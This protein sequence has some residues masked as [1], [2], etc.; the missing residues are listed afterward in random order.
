MKKSIGLIALVL[1][2]F[3]S[4][5]AQE[6]LFQRT[7]GGS[8]AENSYAIE[9]TL[10]GGYISVG[11]TESF[12]KGKKDMLVVKTD[13]MGQV[14]WSSAYGESGDD[15]AWNV[16]VANDSGYVV[17]GNSTSYKANGDAIAV[18]LDKSGK[19]EWARTVASDSLEDGYNII[20]SLYSNGYYITG[21]VKN[22]SN[23]DQGF[24]AK[25]GTGG[26]IRWYKTFGSPGNEEA[27]G[28]AEDGRG[29]VVITGQTTYD[30][31]TNGGLTGSSGSSDA[32]IAKF[33][34][35]GG[36]KWMK[37]Y[38]S[39]ADD[40][41][42]DIKVDRNTYI[43][44]GWTK[45][46]SVGDNDVFVMTCDTSGN[47]VNAQ[48]LGTTGDD[49]GFDIAI[50]P[51]N[52]GFAVVGYAEPQV[53][54]REVLYCDFNSSGALSTSLLVGGSSRD[55]HWPT[56]VTKSGDG[57]FVVL[58]TSRSFNTTGN[59]D[60]YLAKIRKDGST[61]CN[62]TLDPIN[63]FTLNLNSTSFGGALVGLTTQTP[64]VSRTTIST[65]SDSTLCCKL[66]AA[67][68]KTQLEVCA[69]RN[70]SIGSTG[71]RGINYSWK[72]GN[73]KEIS[74]K[75]NPSVS[76]SA[77]TTYKLVVTSNDQEC[78]SD[79][80]FVTVTVNQFLT[81]DLARD[82]SFC[83]GDSATIVG[84]KNL[85]SYLWQGTYINTNNRSFKVK[86]S[87]TIYFTGIDV[88]S[89]TYNDTMVV[90]VNSLPTFNLGSDTTICES[91]AIEL[92]GPGNMKSYNWNSGEGSSQTFKTAAE[93]THNL[94]VVD[95]NG[96]TYS[97][98]ITLLT[99][100]SSPFSLGA[101]D[102]FCMGGTFTILGPGALSGYIWNDTAS[103]LQNIRVT[104]AG[105][106]HL[107][108][109]NSFGCPSSDTIDLTT[110]N[111]PTFSLGSDFG[112]CAGSS[113]YLVGPKD[114]TTYKWNNNSSN[115]SLLINTSGSYWLKVTDE[116]TCSYTDSINVS[117]VSLPVI[118]LGA[119]T[120]ICIGDSLRLS[121]GSG[122]ASYDWSTT[123][124][125]EVIYVMSKN[126]YSV[127]VADQNGCE[128]SAS[129]NVDTM[130]CNSAIENLSVTGL[131]VFPNPTTDH[132]V[133]AFGATTTDKLTTRITDISG[134]V[135]QEE[136]FSTYPGENQVTIKLSEIPSGQYF[137]WLGNSNG[138][139]TL[140]IVVE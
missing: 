116:F 99:N 50:K 86:K 42:W 104:R 88:N 85:I 26:N 124:T 139:T 80:T 1:G 56:D 25:L 118:S 3:S 92:T 78:G 68:P 103:S 67:L 4:V 49:R 21:Y 97:D 38:G 74:K 107:T 69:G 59:D 5:L 29:N 121:P 43:V 19:V 89:C 133:V 140:K 131:R 98:Q 135:L 13:G 16:T 52:A 47:S 15:V 23:A 102:T 82:T 10:D 61:L 119:D 20:R 70:I 46:I 64:S 33:D 93:K 34:S 31:I 73:G 62:S 27:Y 136:L 113:R 11:Y 127:T 132:I 120:V 9:R 134:K 71:I 66:S 22:D 87:D 81:E 55:G 58:S 101:D 94:V 57:G 112:L 126:T 137:L 83:D 17:V 40:A 60:L 8:K 53:G 96:C 75:A 51:A 6:N 115:D 91:Q 108:A 48:A 63:S 95:T 72:D 128:G 123:E 125:T 44:T 76:P 54:N 100:P 84:S 24:L 105:S 45:A 109:F 39:T 12:G 41:G 36:F 110:R 30:S 130:T 114:M 35:T 122:Y 90:D 129:I 65:I 2:L 28:L 138:S 117:N 18:K 111:Q 14:E 7:I 106:Y 32:F 79:S 77:T 37:T